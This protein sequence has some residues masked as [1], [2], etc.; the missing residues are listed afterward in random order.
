MMNNF[1][2]ISSG[3]LDIEDLQPIFRSDD[4]GLLEDLAQA[5]RSLTRQYFGRAVSLY[6]PLY[7]AN[8]CRNRCAYCGFQVHNRIARKKLTFH[9]ID[10]ECR[11][12]ASR[13]IRSCLILTGESR[14]HSPP[15]YIGEAVRI[16]GKYFPNVGLEVYPLETDEYRELY[17]AGADGVTL[18]QETYD[19]LRYDELHLAGPKKNYDYRVGAPERIARA[20][21]R[22]IGMGALL[23][24]TDWREDVPK[25]FSHVRYL[26]KHYPGVEYTLSFPRLRPVAGDEGG[27]YQALSDKDMVKIICAARLVFPRVGINVST[28]EDPAFRDGIVE[29]GVTKMSAGSLTTVGGYA[30][31]EA[32]SEDDGQ[33]CV[34]DPRNIKQ[35]KSMLAKKGLD[36]VTTDWRNIV[37]EIG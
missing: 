16:A 3:K 8:Y 26:E 19:R 22:H 12:L 13:G 27:G 32:E 36:P 28:R 2:S 33:F 1:R 37:N 5:A 14:Y 34:H 7:I 9:E 20:G 23:G 4:R 6:A 17:K 11:A 30:T 31:E 21:F 29:L 10:R 15:E 24:L 25:L 35:I 18:F